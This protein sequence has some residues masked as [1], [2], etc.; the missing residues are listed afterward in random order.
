M[1]A[2]RNDF[3]LLFAG[4]PLAFTAT[5][6]GGLT[7]VAIKCTVRR[8]QNG[9]VIAECSTVDGGIEVLSDTQAS[10]LF[11]SDVTELWPIAQ[12]YYDVQADPNAAESHTLVEGRI[13]MKYRPTRSRTSAIPPSVAQG[14]G[15]IGTVS[16]SAQL[17]TSISGDLTA[18]IGTVT[19][20]AAGTAGTT[21][22]DGFTT[23]AH[24]AWSNWRALLTGVTNLI[25]VRR[26]TGGSTVAEHDVPAGAGTLLDAASLSG[27]VG[28]ESWATRR[29]YGQ[30]A[31][32]NVAQTT[33]G[34]QPAGGTAGVALTIG[35][36]HAA[37]FDGA[38]DH[39]TRGDTMT[40]SGAVALSVFSE[41]TVD[42]VASTRYLFAIGASGT[43]TLFSLI[44]TNATTI[45]VTIG[46]ANRLFTAPTLTT[47][48]HKV[49]VALGAG[50]GIGTL[51][52]WVDGV[53]LAQ[54]SVSSG[55]N[56][57][58]LGTTACSIGTDITGLSFHDGRIS[59]LI[60]WNADFGAGGLA[61]DLARAL[62]L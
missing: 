8:Y 47:G 9:P 53:E 1:T 20:V 46:G 35:T 41:F 42:S 10:V 58:N 27:F 2:L 17:S 60:L 11:G 15:S 14:G 30:V 32:R 54:A 31:S 29:W 18:S 37:D 6:E 36:H 12:L 38:G 5:A 22:L 55:S 59:E 24:A 49:L 50:A 13:G 33:E 25:T 39:F 7:G 61:A 45:G 44:V 62:L 28:A 51:R 4:D 23:P 3:G 21:P 56:T 43:G 52:C 48:T 19:M 57:L 26:T 34:N 40:L 16:I